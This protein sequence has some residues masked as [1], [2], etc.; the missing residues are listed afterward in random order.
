LRRVVM[1][2]DEIIRVSDVEWDVKL[3]FHE[4]VQF[5]Q[6]HVREQLRRQIPDGDAL[7][8]LSLSLLNSIHRRITADNAAQQDLS[9]WIADRAFQ[10]SDQSFVVDTVEKLS[11]VAFENPTGTGEVAADFSRE[12]PQTVHRRM[13]AFPDAAGIGIEDERTVEER[14]QHAVD[15]MVSDAVAHRGLVDDP[16]FRVKNV[17]LLIRPVAVSVLDELLVE[18]KK[19]VFQMSLKDLDVRLGTFAAAELAPGGE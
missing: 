5:V 7:S 18:C 15:G 8:S 2:K 14:I 3:F 9:V 11:D 13:R 19:A 16:M 4:M 1:H 6:I 12:V 17:K 10:D